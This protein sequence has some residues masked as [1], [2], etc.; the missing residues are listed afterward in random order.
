ME[1]PKRA[2]Y[3]RR[4]WVSILVAGVVVVGG[5]TSA[6]PAS[7]HAGSGE[8]EVGSELVLQALGHLAHDMSSAGVDAS[9]EKIGDVLATKDQA[10]V[11]IVEV[12][13]AKA[14]LEAGQVRQG[15]RPSP[16]LDH[17]G[18]CLD[19][20][21][22]RRGDRH[23]GRRRRASRPRRS[24]HDGYGISRRLAAL[25]P[26]RRGSGLLL[27]AGKDGRSTTSSAQQ[28]GTSTAGH[29]IEGRIMTTVLRQPVSMP[30][31]VLDVR[32]RAPSPR[33]HRRAPWHRLSG[34]P[35]SRARQQPG[36][37]PGRGHGQRVWNPDHHRLHPGAVLQPGAGERERLGPPHHHRRGGRMVRARRALLGLPGHVRE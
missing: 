21:G 29:L 7:A 9:M 24:G 36:L 3:G 8:T 22:R 26:V 11:N 37:E 32:R 30:P 13:Q 19:G 31:S 6:A 23:E 27:Q 25:P 35:G 5:L 4:I 33:R 28:P 2:A 14:A 17:S 10:G 18:Q 15:A 34:V 20:A 1:T 16:A 12:K